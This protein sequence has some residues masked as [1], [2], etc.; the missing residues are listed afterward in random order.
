MR[1]KTALVYARRRA[2]KA[3]ENR[4]KTDLEKAATAAM[5]EIDRILKSQCQDS[6]TELSKANHRILFVAVIMFVDYCALG[7][8]NPYLLLALTMLFVMA[9]YNIG[10]NTKKFSHVSKLSDIMDAWRSLVRRNDFDTRDAARRHLPL[11]CLQ[12]LKHLSLTATLHFFQHF[13]HLRKLLR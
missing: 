7:A 13:L 11:H 3:V 12:A 2:I 1:R 4:G 5:R 10:H 9:R 8:L 6:C